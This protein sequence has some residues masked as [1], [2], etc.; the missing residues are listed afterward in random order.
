MLQQQPREIFTPLVFLVSIVAAVIDWFYKRRGGKRPTKNERLLFCA[1]ILLCAVL[2]A[3][4][5]LYG[6]QAGPLGSLTGFLLVALFGTWELGRWRVRRKNP[7]PP[8]RPTPSQ[9]R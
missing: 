1:A 6:A 2:I 9:S 8:R 7:A 5:A 4:F 3:F